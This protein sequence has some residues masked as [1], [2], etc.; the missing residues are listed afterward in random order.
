MNN[1]V[2]V[3]FYTKNAI[4][5]LENYNLAEA[6]NWVEENADSDCVYVYYI[7]EECSSLEAVLDD[8]NWYEADGYTPLNY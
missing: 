4:A 6:I 5:E 3:D 1:F 7:Q 2:I 8:G